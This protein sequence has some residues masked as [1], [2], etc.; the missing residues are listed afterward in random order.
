MSGSLLLDLPR[1]LLEH[2]VV[3]GDPACAAALAQTCRFFH[4]LIYDAHDSLIWRGLF[5][6]QIFDDPRK[7]ITSRGL[8]LTADTY[9]WKS[10][11]QRRVRAASI[12][13][14]RSNC[15]LEPGELQQTL[16]TLVYMI[17]N[18]PPSTSDYA[19]DQISYN[20]AWVKTQLHEGE[21]LDMLT[22]SDLTL[23]VEEQQ[24]RARLH[25]YFGLT[26]RDL[27]RAVRDDNRAFVYDFRNYADSN[28]WGPF[29]QDASGRVN[30]VHIRAIQHLMSMHALDLDGFLL[31]TPF[32]A[33]T[34][35]SLPFCQTLYDV[36]NSTL[37]ESDW[38]GVEGRWQCSFCFIDHTE[39]L[40]KSIIA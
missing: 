32:I 40:R 5:L 21:F 17:V 8:P 18:I 13:R 33:D 29:L 7:C 19:I 38:A 10:D 1:E 25:T 34:P 30:W 35:M 12:I 23:R 11:V 16:E 28:C 14:S 2:I 37:D 4:S 39:L 6:A 26:R 27:Q 24:L 15:S 3:N 36:N 20:L 9:D 31:G 22:D